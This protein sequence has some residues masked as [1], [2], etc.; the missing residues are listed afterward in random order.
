ML[1]KVTFTKS[2]KNEQT[3]RRCESC[4]PNLHDLE[5]SLDLVDQ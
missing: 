3:Q 4:C 2:H 5:N 1:R